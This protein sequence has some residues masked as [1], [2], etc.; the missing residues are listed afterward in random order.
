MERLVYIFRNE[1]GLYVKDKGRLYFTDRSFKDATEGFAYV[2]ILKEKESYGFITGSM[3][4]KGDVDLVKCGSKLYRLGGSYWNVTE[5]NGV[6]VAWCYS[7]DVLSVYIDGNVYT[8]WSYNE[9]SIYKVLK[10]KENQRVYVRGYWVKELCEASTVPTRVDDALSVSYWS[11][12]VKGELYCFGGKYYMF[13]PM[14]GCMTNYG[15]VYSGSYSDLDCIETI[16][17]WEFLSGMFPEKE[18]ICF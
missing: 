10:E 11:Y 9:E 13:D 7:G 15:L 12:G 8:D 3:V 5:V 17:M 2:K 16:D 4:S 6:E 18:K 14:S 1:K